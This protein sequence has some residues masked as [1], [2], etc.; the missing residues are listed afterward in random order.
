M[1]PITSLG[2]LVA[3]V[4]ASFIA[5]GLSE[6]VSMDDVAIPALV[7]GFAWL[8]AGVLVLA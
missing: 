1:R 2:V 6:L 4:S 7:T 5:T 3:F 8:V